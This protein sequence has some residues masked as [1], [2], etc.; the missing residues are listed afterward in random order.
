MGDYSRDREEYLLQGIY[1]IGRKG[2]RRNG[3]RKT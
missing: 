1:P 3:D 2:K